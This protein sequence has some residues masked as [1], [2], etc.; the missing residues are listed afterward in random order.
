MMQLGTRWSAGGEPPRSVPEELRAEIGRVE[1][2][3]PPG[4]PMPSWT[5]TW[6]EG[7][8]IAELDTGI[9]VTLDADGRAVSRR[10]DPMEDQE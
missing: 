10:F 5:L 3:L 7:R 9:E 1:S 2:T 6:L 8:P 4:Q